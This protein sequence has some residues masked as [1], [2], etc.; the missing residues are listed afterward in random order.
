MLTPQMIPLRCVIAALFLAATRFFGI[1]GS[2][3]ELLP[4]GSKSKFYDTSFIPSAGG[5]SG[6]ELFV[7]LHLLKANGNMNL[8]SDFT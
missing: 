6:K 8:F 4:D 3:T 2:C 7:G 5:L 1:C